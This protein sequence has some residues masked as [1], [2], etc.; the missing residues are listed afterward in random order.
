MIKRLWMVFVLV[1]I[2]LTTVSCGNA[3]QPTNPTNGTPVEQQTQQPADSSY[4]Y[5]ITEVNIP[6][7]VDEGYPGPKEVTT[8][9]N[10]FLVNGTL[11]IPAP[12]EGKAVVK[13][14][15]LT[16]GE[17]GTP[18]VGEIYLA[19]TVSSNDP[20]AP[21]LISFSPE[22]DPRGTQDN[23]GNIVFTNIAPGQ[24]AIVIYSLGG[25]V[26]I[27]DPV[28]GDTFLFEVAAGETK[29]IGV[30]AVP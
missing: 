24:Y 11:E 14:Q 4:P 29:D 7:V 8:A 21:P 3:A 23:N 17:G 15:A 19:P 28:S 26:I 30:I 22:T 27:S 12:A 9:L 5:P 2:M 6:I 1:M 18:Y 16:P 20:S 10:P 25:T 13:G